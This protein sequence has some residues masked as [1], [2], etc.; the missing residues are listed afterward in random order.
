MHPVR[1]VLAILLTLCC[2]RSAAAAA[3]PAP[4]AIADETAFLVVYIP[5]L[6][7]TIDHLE[8][9][10]VAVNPASLRGMMKMGLGMTLGDPEFKAFGKGPVALVMGPGMPKPTFALILPTTNAQGYIDALTVMGTM[11]KAVGN[12]VVLSELP[13]GLELG[14]RIVAKLGDIGAKPVQGDIRVLVAFDRVMQNYGAFLSQMA[15]MA[16]AMA[17]KQAGQAEMTKLLPLYAAALQ[18]IGG[19]VAMHQI[20]LGFN[21][22]AITIDTITEAKP[23]SPL[24]KALIAPAAMKSASEQRLGPDGGAVMGSLCMNVPALGGYAKHVLGELMKRPEAKNLIPAEMPA[25]IDLAMKAYTGDCAMRLRGGEAKGPAFNT[26]AIYQVTD[27]TAALDAHFKGVELFFSDKNA[28]GKMYQAMGITCVA[29]R[30][31]R[32]V[33]TTKVHTLAMKMDAAKQPAAQ[34]EQMQRLMPPTELAVDKNFLLL[35]QGGAID[36]MLKAPAK[37]P[38]LKAR[39]VHGPG[40]AGYLDLDPAGLALVFTG[41]MPF[42]VSDTTVTKLKAITTDQLFTGAADIDAGRARWTLTLPT[43]PMADIGKAFEGA[44]RQRHQPQGEN[45]E[46]EPAPKDGP[47]L[48]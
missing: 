31:A 32:S 14:E 7:A 39:T 5:D 19:E 40:H 41:M 18:M 29:T 47:A 17:G 1:P 10:A 44:G 20:D 27:G 12:N 22:Q 43:K 9:A 37:G 24:A 48:F 46:P 21:A 8:A 26:Q 28:L 3:I 13:D 38:T 11:G 4:A 36:G 23:G 34:G 15:M 25:I 16:G 6:L 35:A 45:M 2:W 30:D 42:P 33:G